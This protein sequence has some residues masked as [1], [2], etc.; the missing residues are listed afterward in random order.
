[1]CCPLV[2]FFLRWK[3]IKKS[4]ILP[5]AMRKNRFVMRE[6]MISVIV[7]Y[8]NNER[9]VDESVE[10]AL[11][12]S[13]KDIEVILV[14]N[15]SRKE[16]IPK[17]KDTR[18]RV[19]RYEESLGAALARN[20]GVKNAKGE[21][22]AFLDSDDI[23][24]DDKL[25]KQMKIMEK[26]RIHGEAPAICFTGRR[27]INVSGVDTGKIVGC[28]K[29]VRF[30]NLVKSNQ[31]NCSSVLMRKELAERYPFPEGNLHEDYAV[32]LSI[33]KEG[34]Y[35]VGINRPLIRYRLSPGSRSANKLKSAYMTYQDYRYVGLGI[36]E[37][38]RRMIS[39]TIAGIKKYTGLYKGTHR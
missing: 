21:F 8:H 39:Y 19:L 31:I 12:Q 4:V 27:L 32:W 18:L 24:E 9:T 6:N 15:G 3:K 10:S 17:T 36:F 23:W 28:D 35:A 33:L 11:N 20:E 26:A 16:F 22:V 1:M 38:A 25:A 14:D 2:P 5:K 7:P 37:S 34:G 13:Y 29:V 30:E